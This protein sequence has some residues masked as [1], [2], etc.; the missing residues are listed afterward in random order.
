[1]I[2]PTVKLYRLALMDRSRS[3]SVCR[4]FTL[5]SEASL[6]SGNRG[7]S[8]VPQSASGCLVTTA[9]QSVRSPPLDWKSLI[10]TEA[11]SSWLNSWSGRPQKKA[12]V[13]GPLRWIVRRHCLLSMCHT[14]TIK[15]YYS[16]WTTILLL[17]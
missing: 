11:C 8:G 12:L 5:A 1:M 6:C 15:I 16:Y 13:T 14:L 17:N 4:D 7:E 3:T 2:L 9:T 10:T